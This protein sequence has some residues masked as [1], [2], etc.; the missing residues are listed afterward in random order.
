MDFY[1]QPENL[2]FDRNGNLKVSDFGLSV[3]QKVRFLPPCDLGLVQIGKRG[4][5][6]APNALHRAAHL[7][8]GQKVFSMVRIRKPR[9]IDFRDGRLRCV[10]HGAMHIVH[11]ST[12]VSVWID[13]LNFKHS[14]T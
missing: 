12:P 2:L 8:S 7:P 13:S 3:L 11:S 9:T 4:T 14:A 6:C 10:L 1:L 5:C